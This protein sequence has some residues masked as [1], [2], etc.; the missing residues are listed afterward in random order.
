MKINMKTGTLFERIR[1]IPDMF[2]LAPFK[3]YK[4]IQNT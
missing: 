2:Q 4:H 3:K 1:R